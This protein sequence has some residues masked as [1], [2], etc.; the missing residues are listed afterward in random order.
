MELAE[1][2]AKA[3]PASAK[4]DIGNV[5][6]AMA[7][8]R[9]ATSKA[10][11]ILSANEEYQASLRYVVSSSFDVSH[12]AVLQ[13]HLEGVLPDVDFKVPLSRPLLETIGERAGLWARVTA[14]I[15]SVL[16]QVC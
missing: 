2:G 14:P 3:L 4:G 5:P 16:A 8:I 10:K 15:D 9:K 6:A 11:E 1:K 7:K 12:C 13:L